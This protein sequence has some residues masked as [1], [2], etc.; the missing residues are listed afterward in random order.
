MPDGAPNLGTLPDAA[1]A[2]PEAPQTDGVLPSNE[3][4]SGEPDRVVASLRAELRE[5]LE[6]RPK[7]ESRLLGFFSRKRRTESEVGVQTTLAPREP[8]FISP[9]FSESAA[10]LATVHPPDIEEPT[11]P[12]DDEGTDAE[13][14]FSP[15]ELAETVFEEEPY[16]GSPSTPQDE[17]AAPPDRQPVILADPVGP[18]DEEGSHEADTPLPPSEM[19]AEP[20]IASGADEPSAE[21]AS[22]P[23]ALQGEVLPPERSEATERSREPERVITMQPGVPRPATEDPSVPPA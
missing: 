4:P 11:Q 14:V 20:E 21:A 13:P 23:A 5:T 3:E 19:I 8:A 1:P 22:Q 15:S 12:T 16:A 6:T 2:S 17:D 18:A 10:D 9:D 7:S